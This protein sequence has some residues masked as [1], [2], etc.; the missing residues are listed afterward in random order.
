[1][2]I[3]INSKNPSEPIYKKNVFFNIKICFKNEIYLQNLSKTYTKSYPISF[4]L[5]NYFSG[6]AQNFYF[7]MS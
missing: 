4:H 1:M 5:L 2:N 7:K 3:P 6:E